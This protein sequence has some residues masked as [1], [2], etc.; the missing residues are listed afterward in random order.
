MTVRNRAI[1]SNYRLEETEGSLNGKKEREQQQKRQ[2]L[3][4]QISQMTQIQDSNERMITSS[5]TYFL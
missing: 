2:R 5:A 1:A 4:P 3:Y